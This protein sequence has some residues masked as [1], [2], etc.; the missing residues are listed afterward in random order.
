MDTFRRG[1]SG[2]SWAAAREASAHNDAVINAVTSFSVNVVGVLVLGAVYMNYVLLAD[3]IRPLFWAGILSIPL[4]Q[5]K[6]N[7]VRRVV[8]DARRRGG[9]AWTGLSGTL[10]KVIL[11]VSL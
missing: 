9:G 2:V 7:L 10:F 11:Q 3:Y 1:V 8:H 6:K 4:H 5:L